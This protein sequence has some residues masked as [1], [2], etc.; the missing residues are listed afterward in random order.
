MVLDNQ[1]SYIWG[2]LAPQVEQ[3][4]MIEVYNNGIRY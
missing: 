3:N 2:M 4:T 1:I